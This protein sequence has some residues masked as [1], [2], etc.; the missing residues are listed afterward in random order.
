MIYSHSLWPG[1]SHN[2]VVEFHGGAERQRQR[3]RERC[4]ITLWYSLG[5]GSHKVPC[6]FKRK[7]NRLHL[8]MGVIGCKSMCANGKSTLSIFEKYNLPQEQQWKTHFKNYFCKISISVYGYFRIPHKVKNF[9]LVTIC[10]FLLYIF[11]FTTH[12]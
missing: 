8:V 1:H 11:I 9:I 2:S 5:W 12:S 3:H 10:Y 4:H 7:E 6:S